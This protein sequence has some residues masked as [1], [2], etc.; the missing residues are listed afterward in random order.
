MGVGVKIY[1]VGLSIVCHQNIIL[2]SELY[3]IN[4]RNVP[5]FVL[6]MGFSAGIAAGM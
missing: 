6:G 2:Q 1:G 4:K 5:L 3:F